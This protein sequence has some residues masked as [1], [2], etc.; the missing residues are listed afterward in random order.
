M[1]IWAFMSGGNLSSPY[2]DIVI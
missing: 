2:S 1:A